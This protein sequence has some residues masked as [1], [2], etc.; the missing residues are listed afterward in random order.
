MSKNDQELSFTALIAS[1]SQPGAFPT[2]DNQPPVVVQT[3]ASVV[4]LAGDRAYKLKKPKN[5]GFFDYSTPEQ[6]RHFCLEEVRLNSRLAAEVYLGVAPVLLPKGNQPRIGPPCGPD[7]LPQPGSLF[8][9]DTVVDFAVVMVRLPDEATLEASLRNQGA[10]VA[11][12]A[13]IA[14]RV[15]QFHMSA[16]TSDEISRYGSIETIRGNWEENLEQMHPYI[17]RVLDPE[18]WD[19]IANFARTFIDRRQR[20]FAARVRDEHIRDCHGDLRLQH[21]YTLPEPVGATHLEPHTPP[22][23]IEIIDCVEFNER[24]RFSDV[25]SEVAFLVMEL[26]E[27]GRTDLAQAFSGAYVTATGDATLLELLPFYC[28]YRACVRGK[29]LAFQLDEPEVPSQQKEAAGERAARLFELAATYARSPTSPTLLMI[30]GLMG[31]GKSRLAAGIAHATGWPVVSSDTVRKKLAGVAAAEPQP[32][33]FGSGIYTREWTEQTYGALLAE[34]STILS[35][36][37]SLV[38]DASFGDRGT[39]TA[40]VST[41]RRI[42]ARPVFAE[43]RCASEVALRR[44]AERWQA[45]VELTRGVEPGEGMASDGRPDLYEAQAAAWQPVSQEE[46]ATGMAH[47]VVDTGEAPEI[48]VAQLLADIRR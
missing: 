43:C 46:T 42:G 28:C 48:S 26:D 5:F 17:G 45:R 32:H 36:D 6:R 31:T 18:T 15:A 29:V 44:L 21:I 16:P 39:R 41:A 37:R 34:A 35:E 27:A 3:H 7:H 24:F 11:L 12:L 20:F 25:A 47:V 22:M 33:T 30:G 1:L 19:A 9:G 14:R 2:E 40:A 38:L 10:D 23:R 4:L 13:S 8:Q